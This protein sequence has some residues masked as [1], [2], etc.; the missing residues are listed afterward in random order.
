MIRILFSLIT[1]VSRCEIQSLLVR[2]LCHPLHRPYVHIPYLEL[3][4]DD[5]R[6]HPQVIA[7]TELQLHN[8]GRYRMDVLVSHTLEREGL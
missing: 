3:S 5:L 7:E 8:G 1:K 2:Q 4:L 6:V